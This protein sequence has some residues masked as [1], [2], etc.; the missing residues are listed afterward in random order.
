MAAFIRFRPL[1]ESLDS[2]GTPPDSAN[3]ATYNPWR[4]FFPAFAGY[5]SEHRYYHQEPKHLEPEL[6]RHFHKKLPAVVDIPLR[7]VQPGQARRIPCQPMIQVLQIA[8]VSEVN[9]RSRMHQISDQKIGIE[10]LLRRQVGVGINRVS[11]RVGQHR[12]VLQNQTQRELRGKLPI[13]LAAHDVVVEDA[14][15][16]ASAARLR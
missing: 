4:Y 6:V 9:R 8:V 16:Q 11:R 3:P 12:V 14:S 15:P 2:T 5:D 7:R 10:L 13:P 1:L